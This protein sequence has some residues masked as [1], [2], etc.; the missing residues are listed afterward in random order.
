MVCRVKYIRD[1]LRSEFNWEAGKGVF[2]VRTKRGT[3]LIFCVSINYNS[4][5]GKKYRH[6]NKWLVSSM[7]WWSAG[8]KLA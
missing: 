8:S 4:V 2:V 5:A 7:E 1:K 3:G 6:G